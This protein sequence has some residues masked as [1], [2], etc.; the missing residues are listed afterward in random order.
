MHADQIAFKRATLVDLE[1]LSAEV[2]RERNAP[3]I[4]CSSCFLAFPRAQLQAF[5]L[6]TH[7]RRNDPSTVLQRATAGDPVVH[8]LAANSTSSADTDRMID[9]TNRL[10]TSAPIR[11]AF[12]A[13]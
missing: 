8:I 3:T 1:A 13:L 12:M 5:T 9:G 4:K 2:F 10:P 11:N 7:R 6:D